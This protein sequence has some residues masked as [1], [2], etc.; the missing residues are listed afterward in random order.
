M[1]WQ[2]LRWKYPKHYKII[3]KENFQD[4]AQKVM[5]DKNSEYFADHFAKYFTKKT[6]QQQCR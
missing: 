6:S 4:V 1:L 3:M 2:L 5:N